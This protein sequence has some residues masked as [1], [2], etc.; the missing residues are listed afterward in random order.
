MFLALL[1]QGAAQEVVR[2]EAT[3]PYS[4]DRVL[5]RAELFKPD[6][7]GRFPAVI[8]MHGCGGWQ[9]AVRFALQNHAR[10][11]QRSGFVVL[12]LD[13][14]GPRD[15]SGGRLCSNDRALYKALAFRTQDA[16]DAMKYLRTQ[17]FVV[18]D[19]IFLMGQSNGGAVAIRAAKAATITAYDTEGSAFR[20]IVAYYPWCGEFGRSRVALASPLLILAGGQDN[21]VPARECQ[22]IVANGAE[23][24]VKVY[25]EAAHS[26]DLDILPQ[27]Y[28]GKRIGLD[29]EAKD[30][31]QKRM[32]AFFVENLTEDLREAYRPAETQVN[33][34]QG[35]GADF[36]M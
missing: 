17:D 32:L 30:D 19:N 21:W 10:Y 23:L 16:F 13:S 29:R 9:P 35:T 26:F 12:N 27:K 5:L 36:D 14:F 31:S 1:G 8:L 22:N 28:L 25:P 6:G 33:V 20:G 24:R 18:R 2:F 11:L 4:S 15:S 3:Q 7:P 34:A